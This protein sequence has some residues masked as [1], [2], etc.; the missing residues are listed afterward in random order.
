MPA[1]TSSES[2]S[3]VNG[4]VAPGFEAVRAA[5]LNSFQRGDE[6]GASLAVCIDNEMVVDLWGGLRDSRAGQLWQQDTL[7]LVFSTSKGLA[8]LALALAHSRGWLDYE[9][10]VSRYWPEFACHGKEAITVRQL[11]AHQ[12][13]LSSVDQALTPQLIGDLDALAAVLARQRPRWTPGERRGYHPVTL[14]FYQNELLRR[15]D[16]QHRTIGEVLQ[17]EIAGPLDAEAYIG[18]PDEISD[19]RVARLERRASVAEQ[20]QGFKIYPGKFVLAMM[21]PGH[22]TRLA[23]TNPRIR[24]LEEFSTRSWL[25]VQM[26]SANAVANARGIARIYGEF[27]SG[28]RRLGLKRETLALLDAGAEPLPS[29]GALDAVLYIDSAYSLGFWKPC[30]AFQSGANHRI[31]GTPGAGGS[32]G[33][34]DPSLGMGF[35][36]VPN[37]LGLHMIEDPR[38]NALRA[39]VYDCARALHRPPE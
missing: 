29:S 31:Y 38:A 22:V 12:A 30:T 26:P 15:V 6:V 3:I 35:A 37:R 36:Y 14:G 33:F 8:A 1:V 2:M 4:H 18:L 13:G 10:P 28:G 24:S 25:K 20:L 9:Q 39:V 32:V 16:P 11:L 23:F 17:Q 7:A 34:A 5:F 27:A 21:W 19:D